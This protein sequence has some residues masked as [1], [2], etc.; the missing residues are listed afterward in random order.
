MTKRKSRKSES[1]KEEASLVLHKKTKKLGILLE[2]SKMQSDFY[3]VMTEGSLEE[4]H[5]SN[6]DDH[7]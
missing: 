4:W 2:R 7:Y 1:Q 5:I 6:I 3:Y